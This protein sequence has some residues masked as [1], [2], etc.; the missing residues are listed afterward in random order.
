MLEALS[1]IRKAAA[2][3]D[4]ERL[5]DVF[6]EMAEYRIPRESRSLFEKLKDASEK[7]EYKTILKLMPLE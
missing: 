5:D 6:A 2:D 3:M 4:C 1:E 7:Y